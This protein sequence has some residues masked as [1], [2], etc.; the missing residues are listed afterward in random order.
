MTPVMENLQSCT[1][2]IWAKEALF[3]DPGGNE[4]SKEIS[5]YSE[6]PPNPNDP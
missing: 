3:P 2:F 5:E 1:Y 6:K 4:T